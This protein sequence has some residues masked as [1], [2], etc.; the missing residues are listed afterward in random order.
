MAL[1]QQ[2]TGNSAANQLDGGTGNDTAVFAGTFASYSIS[3]DF[4]NIRYTISGASTG[5]NIIFGVAL[6][7][8]SDMLRSCCQLTRLPQ[9][10]WTLRPLTTLQ[11][12][13]PV[14]IWFYP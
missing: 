11:T 13:P 1:H 9:P 10:Q 3:Y 4:T 6:F 2:G 12:L 14:P 7:K 5:T 8:F